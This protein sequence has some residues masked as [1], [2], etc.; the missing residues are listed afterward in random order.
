MRAP[1][2]T[3]LLCA[4]LLGADRKVSFSREIRPILSENCIACHGPDEKGRKGELRLDD[5]QDAKRDR[6]GDRV[7]SPGN[8]DKSLLISRILS[9]DPDEVMPPPKQHKTVS[10]AQVELLRE[11]IRQGAQWGR[12]WSYEPVVRSEVPANGE[13]NP[14]DAFLADRHR[15]E[16]LRW[17]A[18][19]DPAIL[20]R[21]TALDLT[22]L[23]PSAE[24][25][26]KLTGR[27]QAEVVAHFLAKPAYGEHWARQ[28]LD[29]ARYADS[30]GYPSDPGRDIWAYRDWVIRA[31][32]ANQPFDRFTVEQLAG[33]LLP[34][35][36]DDQLIATAF[37]R[38]TMTQNEG[39]TSD[40]E[41][42]I[43]AVIDRVNT[44]YAVWM[45]TT[46]AC[47]QCH[48]HKYDPIT[49]TEYFR[50]YAF[51]NQTADADKKDESPLHTFTTDE[52]RARRKELEGV[53][54]ELDKR[55][56]SPPAAWLAG[57]DK[58]ESSV[59]LDAGWKSA[60]PAKVASTAK[61]GVEI[62]D[63][64]TVSLAGRPEQ[65]VQTVDIPLDS[66]RLTALRLETFPSGGNFVLTDI[67][68]QLIRPAA[69]AVPAAKFVRIELPGK[70]RFLQLAEVEVFSKG[71]N[72]AQGRPAK[73][74]SQYVDA[75]AGRAVDGNTDGAYAKG[76]VAHSAEEDSPW[77]EVELTGELPVEK[78]TVWNR[79]DGVS[80]RLKGFELVLLDAARKVVWRSAP[81]PAPA[82]DHAFAVGGP[83]PVNFTAAFADHEQPGFPAKSLV[84]KAGKAE[85]WAVAPQADRPHRLTLAT[86]APLSVTPGSLLRVTLIQKSVHKQHVLGKFRLLTSGDPAAATGAE[87]P[88]EVLAAAAVEPAARNDAQKSALASYYARKVSKASATERKQLATAQEMLAALKPVTVPI[89]KELG[90]KE[91]RVTK[92]QL[93]GNWQN[94]GDE[95]SPG[96][97][98]AF[99]PLSKD[100]AADRLAFARWLV[101]RENPLTARVTVNRMWETIFG[102]GIVRTSEEFGS[103]GD[104][105]IHPELLDWLAD[106]FVRTGWD[107]KRMLTLLCTSRAYCQSSASDPKLNE[108]DPDNRLLA[109]GP[110]FRPTG[111]LLRDQALAVSGLLSSKMYGKPVRPPRPAL[112]LS[113]AFGG[114]NDWV[115]STGED[116][117]RRSV[118]TETRRNSPYPSFATFDAPNR[119]TCTIRRD[120]SNTPLQAFVTLN[121][122]V[123]V[124]AQQA[125]ARRLMKEAADDDSRI[126]LAYRL[127]VA[128]QPSAKEIEAVRI[129]LSR[130]EKQYAA[131]PALALKMASE[132]LGA[133]P[134][135]TDVA[136]L[137]AWTVAAG[138]IM[139]LDEFLMR[140]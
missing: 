49:I 26:D 24:E 135:G 65:D 6:D 2:L 47:A 103:Q 108:R 106:E 79:A 92:V 131:D 126:R 91:R 30:A 100:A 107:V 128:R 123:H 90:E 140:R 88:A 10:P 69:A 139:N 12:H 54:A 22:G 137:A 53:I 5:E 84:A 15:R 99:P 19:A 16:G 60:R 81:T 28:W 51:L 37:H 113:T 11:W 125:F 80:D 31:L 127:T 4:P 111:E 74:S 75:A 48:T 76:S 109:R 102:V 70:K 73:L 55:F 7:I 39:G 40:E 116:R 35:P 82:K 64:G 68:A 118:Y 87:L 57:Q 122:P 21:R 83:S 25:L 120:R 112:G 72:V 86:S 94:L 124:E 50:S 58:W 32:N 66:E 17:S 117:W 115:T 132:P 52:H 98:S 129:L 42:R 41:F 27:P 104:L 67:R 44:T 121:D 13:K 95:V 29:L 119:E 105:P 59:R 18:P 61:R 114:S 63:D 89:M 38:N 43:A 96:T 85:G 62:A 71:A 101:S 133:P 1:L 9:K 78:V 138:V 20:V 77:W 45:G 33:D 97:P 23:P 36:T 46:M 134:A 110:R 130:S 56:A 3:L 8:P 34:N 93:R 136:K 14:V